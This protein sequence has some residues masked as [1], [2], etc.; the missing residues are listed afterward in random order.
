MRATEKFPAA[1]CRAPVNSHAG[2]TPG[3]EATTSGAS[4][5]CANAAR[6]QAGQIDSAQCVAGA[7]SI[8]ESAA[9]T[10]IRQGLAALLQPDAQGNVHEEELQHA[11][12][13]HLLQEEH[14]EAAQF[15]VQALEQ[16][17]AD[18]SVED[19]VKA[20]LRKTVE[21]SLLDEQTAERINGA[22][23]R[24]AQLDSDHS[25]L[26]D[27]RGGE[28][29]GTVAVMQ[30]EQ[31]IERATM[32]LEAIERGDVEAPSRALDAPSNTTAGASLE[33]SAVGAAANVG[34]D[35]FLWK[36][37]SERDGRL[38]VLFPP[39]LS[40]RIESAALYS[41]LPPSAENV[42]ERGRFTGDD[43]NGGRA[44]FRFTKP[45]GSYPDGVYV[46]A[47][48]KDGSVVEFRVGET[49]RRNT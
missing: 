5:S 43:H 30:L 26:F 48:L 34:R 38:V 28:G 14:P 18:G 19:A 36:P 21:A 23:F 3:R 41:A 29:D 11:L 49:S 20:A 22:T 12:V 17:L 37:V 6:L 45:G 32:T 10:E 42:L 46:V 27:D 40:G 13:I 15:Y 7:S 16:L 4:D 8:K 35:G 25:A 31:A 2:A 9:T 44:H 47:H 1:S 39:G 33:G 24:A